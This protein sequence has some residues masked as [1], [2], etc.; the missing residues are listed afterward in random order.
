[1]QQSPERGWDIPVR[2]GYAAAIDS[3]GS[4][5]APF[6]AG[7]S[8]A[9]AVFVMQNEEA[10]GWANAA[11]FLLIGATLA[12]LAT[13][14]F[15]FWSRQFATTPAE[16]EMWWGTEA[17]SAPVRLHHEQHDDMEKHRR[18]SV[19]VRWSY[20]VGLLAFLIGLTFCLIPTGGLAEA[21]G[22]R[23]A[24]VVLAAV[25]LVGELAWIVRTASGD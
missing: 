24:V 10:F 14:Q 6:L 23:V 1:M 11:L 5:A 19:R 9:L 17:Q 2:Y 7:V 22:G 15:S 12:F 16:I 4:V 8:G 20:N 25:G 21:S 13:L 18:L 3:M